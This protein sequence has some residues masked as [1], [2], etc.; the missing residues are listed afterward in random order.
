[1]PCLVNH[2]IYMKEFKTV[3]SNAE[4]STNKILQSFR[5][6]MNFWCFQSYMRYTLHTKHLKKLVLIHNEGLLTKR[7]HCN[8]LIHRVNQIHEGSSIN[9]RC[10][11]GPDKVVGTSA[12]GTFSQ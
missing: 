6:L 3:A 4:C 7:V 1:M 10:I 8:S 12:W 9:A 5:L 2:Q 11:G